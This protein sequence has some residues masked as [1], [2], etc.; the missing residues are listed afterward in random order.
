MTELG[1][2]T[3]SRAYRHNL[4][5]GLLSAR[6]KQVYEYLGLATELLGRPPTSAEVWKMIAEPFPQIPQHSINPRFVELKRQRV[7]REGGI[8]T[9]SVTGRDCVGWQ[10]IRGAQVVPMPKKTPRFTLDGG[11]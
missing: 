10:I 9:C 5:S 2:I 8:V 3:S 11:G 1:A 4:A 7:V 6:R